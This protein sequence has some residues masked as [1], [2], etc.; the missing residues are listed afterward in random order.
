MK[1]ASGMFVSLGG[2]LIFD[3][4]RDLIIQWMFVSKLINKKL[5]NNLWLFDVDAVLKII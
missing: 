4:V 2:N 3:N 5:N 1:A